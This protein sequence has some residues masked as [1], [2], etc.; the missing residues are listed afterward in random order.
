MCRAKLRMKSEQL[1]AE[2]YSFH[3][4]DSPA[5]RLCEN[6][7]WR[8]CTSEDILE[9]FVLHLLAIKM[10]VN[11][12]KKVGIPSKNTF[13][14]PALH[15]PPRHSFL[16]IQASRSGRMSNRT[17]WMRRTLKQVL[18]YQRAINLG[19]YGSAVQRVKIGQDHTYWRG[20]GRWRPGQ[21]WFWKC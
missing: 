21:G 14:T 1:G 19:N 20:K 2:N 6:T 4:A 5:Q 7:A 11:N 18:W 15:F 13:S 10:V 3:F 9:L 16:H 17:H 8:R 12:G